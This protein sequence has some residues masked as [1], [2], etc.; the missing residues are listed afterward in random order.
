MST[1]AGRAAFLP[2]GGALLGVACMGQVRGSERSAL[3]AALARG[4]LGR[5]LR[6]GEVV[7][8]PVPAG[9]GVHRALL[10]CWLCLPVR[11]CWPQMDRPSLFK[12]ATLALVRRQLLVPKKAGPQAHSCLAMWLAFSFFFGAL[13]C[14]GGA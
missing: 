4:S 12:A 14:V 3:L 6:L 9:T 8:A 10:R 1:S 2:P 11:W 13:H 5:S 7:P